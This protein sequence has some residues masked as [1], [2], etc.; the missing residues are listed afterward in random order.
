MRTIF[1]VL[2]CSYNILI[3][4]EKENINH[5]FG[6]LLGLNSSYLNTDNL[7]NYDHFRYSFLPGF[8]YDYNINY[9]WLIRSG[10][11]YTKQ[12]GNTEKYQQTSVHEPEGTGKYFWFTSSISYMEIP[13]ICNYRFRKLPFDI[14]IGIGPSFSYLISA[15]ED[16]DADFKIDYSFKE[17]ISDKLSNF[18]L[19][20]NSSISIMFGLYKSIFLEVGTNFS[21]GIFDIYTSKSDYMN[22]Y[23]ERIDVYFKTR[24]ISTFAIIKY[25][26]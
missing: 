6:L 11:F 13:I 12:G 17:D 7:M 14:L 9:N 20:L 3:G 22:E 26:L 19:S 15:Y 5:E 2:L 8:I 21:Y 10:L 4:S 1:I 18:N 24:S 16:F 23:G 25:S